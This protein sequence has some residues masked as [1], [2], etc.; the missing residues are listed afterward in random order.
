MCTE[1]HGETVLSRGSPFIEESTPT[2]SSVSVWA[3]VGATP[4][5]NFWQASPTC[6]PVRFHE[7]TDVG[8]EIRW[9]NDD[10]TPTGWPTNFQ[11]SLA[12]WRHATQR[13][14]K[15]LLRRS[16]VAPRARRL[17]VCRPEPRAIQLVQATTVPLI[18]EFVSG[19]K[20]C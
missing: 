20:H 2:G 5:L 11:H 9:A 16:F 1:R 15:R 10:F 14:A 8:E 12:P 4:V 6:D 17:D 19:S 3:S 7:K 13:C 18:K